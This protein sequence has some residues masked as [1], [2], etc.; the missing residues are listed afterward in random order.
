MS[1]VGRYAAAGLLLVLAAVGGLWPFLDSGGRYGVALAGAI[2]YPIQIL[3]FWLLMRHREKMNRFLAVWVGGT[4]ARMGVIVVT[5]LVVVRIDAVAPAPALI[6]LGA[7][8]FTLLILEPVFFSPVE[9][10]GAT[11]R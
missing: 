8:F 3:A 2:A 1:P 6:A 4:F 9:R 5:A 11:D 10:G 7:F